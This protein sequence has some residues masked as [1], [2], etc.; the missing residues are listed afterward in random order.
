[1]TLIRTDLNLV[2]ADAREEHSGHDEQ[3]VLGENVLRFSVPKQ[4]I[5]RDGI[6]PG[7]RG[8]ME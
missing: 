3:P 7:E 8:G 5:R 6:L 1:M 4:L 2:G